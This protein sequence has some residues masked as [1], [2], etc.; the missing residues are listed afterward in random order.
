MR[1]DRGQGAADRDMVRA[2]MAEIAALL[3]KFAAAGEPAIIDLRSLPLTPADLAA[4]DERL[5]RGEV[6]MKLNLGTGS[7]IW[8]TAYAGVWRVRDHKEG[9]FCQGLAAGER[10]EINRLPEIVITH[11]DD[12]RAAAARLASDLEGEHDAGNSG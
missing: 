7:S 2:V 11:I 5:G 6:E 3:A 4:L 10:V 8:E 1:A 9:G 12:I